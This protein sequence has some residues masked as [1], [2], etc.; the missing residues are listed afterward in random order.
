[1][2]SVLAL[3]Y[4]GP[5]LVSPIRLFLLQPASGEPVRSPL[6]SLAYLAVALRRAGHTVALWPEHLG[7]LTN[8]NS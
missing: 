7:G 1:M 4:L 8:S 2:R 3:V 6:L 5:I